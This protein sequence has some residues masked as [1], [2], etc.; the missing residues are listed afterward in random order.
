[1][2]MRLMATE[3]ISH[4]FVFTP[5]FIGAFEMFQRASSACYQMYRSHASFI[6]ETTN[7]RALLYIPVDLD[8]SLPYGSTSEDEAA[9]WNLVT[10]PI[11]TDIPPAFDTSLPTPQPVPEIG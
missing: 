3:A 4:L 11:G 1:M 10:F 2:K 5:L 9:D 6:A 8:F 7:G